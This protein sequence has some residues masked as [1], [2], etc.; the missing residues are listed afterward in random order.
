MK[1]PVFVN[2]QDLRRLVRGLNRYA[3]AVG[4]GGRGSAFGEGYVFACEQQPLH[5]QAVAMSHR[6][7]K[8]TRM[9]LQGHIARIKGSIELLVVVSEDVRPSCL[10][11]VRGHPILTSTAIARVRKWQFR[12]F[13]KNCKLGTHSGTLVLDAKDFVRPD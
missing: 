3:A 6:I 7:V 12:P 4:C 8:R 11:V 10:L 9:M 1:S 2:R 13:S 5:F